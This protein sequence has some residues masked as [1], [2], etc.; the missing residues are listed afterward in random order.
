MSGGDVN[1]S[2]TQV[3]LARLIALQSARDH[4]SGKRMEKEEFLKWYTGMQGE[5]AGTTKQESETRVP[6]RAA[7][8][9]REEPANNNNNNNNN[10]N[11]GNRRL[12]ETLVFIVR[13]AWAMVKC[14]FLAFLLVYD[15]TGPSI[16]FVLAAVLLFVLHLMQNGDVLRH[17]IVVRERPAEQTQQ[18]EQQQQQP[19]PQQQQQQQQ[20][21]AQEAPQDTPQEEQQNTPAPPP[22]PAAPAPPPRSF[23]SLCIKLVIVFMESLLPSWTLRELDRHA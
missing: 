11:G 10:N 18:E 5:V 19:Q 7:D 9:P 3:P 8:P 2:S 4:A 15:G 23:V 12:A 6:P 21:P 20:Q 16:S 13:N 22:A 1:F 14:L 17:V